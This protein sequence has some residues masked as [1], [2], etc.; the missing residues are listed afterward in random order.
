MGVARGLTPRCLLLL[1]L[2]LAG[3]AA[4]QELPA[5]ARPRLPAGG[6]ESGSGTVFFLELPGGTVAAVGAAHSFDPHELAAAPAVEFRLGRTGVPVARSERLLAPPG[7][8]FTDPSG[9]L[10]ED[11]MVF[12]LDAPPAGAR[13]LA[14]AAAGEA[15][16]GERVRILGVPALVPQ[17]EDDLFGRL[18][19]IEA[20]RLEVDLDVPADLRGWG[21]APVLSAKSGRVLGVLE[22]ALPKSGSHRLGLAPIQAVLDAAAEPLEAGRGA[23][24]AE[25]TPR[26]RP[27]WAV[28]AEPRKEQEEA[29]EEPPDAPAATARMAEAE[30]AAATARTAEQES[31]ERAREAEISALEEEVIASGGELGDENAPLPAPDTGPGALVEARH[32]KSK[33]DLEIEYPPPGEIFGGPVGAFLAGHALALQGEL[34]RFDVMIVI[35][36]SLSTAESTGV[37]VNGNGVVGAS[38]LQGLFRGQDPGDSILAAEVAAARRLLANLDPR[39]ARVGVASFAG[40]VSQGGGI[41]VIGGSQMPS[42]LTEQPLTSD[43]PRVERALDAILARGPWGNTHMAAGL[44]QATIELLGLRGS[45]SEPNPKSSKVVLFLTDGLPTL[46]VELNMAENVRAAVRAAERARR[47]GIQV[48]TFAIGQ[49]ALSG[50]IAPIEM[51]SRT[52]GV[53]TPVRHPADIVTAMGEVSLAN[54]ESLTVRNLTTGRDAD[55]VKLA[56]DG[57]WT[58]L[59]GLKVG[60]NRIE[61]TARASDGSEARREIELQHAPDAALPEVPP[62]LVASRNL[63]LEA[64]LQTLKQVGLGIERERDEQTRRDLALQIEE[65]RRQA[66]E[67]AARQRRELRLEAE[68]GTAPSPDEKEPTP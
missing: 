34:R 61:V 44:D 23:R 39:S 51:A 22:A 60:R 6:A 21:G 35:D 38:G 36:V 28:R 30:S 43:Y 4:A 50:P 19:R 15:R 66:Q 1:G 64:R 47:Q 29:R 42:A 7:R 32:E 62:G 67:R 10:A 58:A 41:L 9:S 27:A 11:I 59:V 18:V 14:P 31:A 26:A 12:A 37:D 8:P 56:L 52:G 33:L 25:F 55:E 17:D 40:D 16:E 24:F 68:P 5:V 57:T 13:S 65:E 46:P 63:L 2:L 53:F 45:L 49:E 54:I 20:G 48:H 3:S